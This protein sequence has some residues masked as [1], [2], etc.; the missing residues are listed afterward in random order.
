MR[1]QLLVLNPTDSSVGATIS[2]QPAAAANS[3]VTVDVVRATSLDATDVTFNGAATP[4]VDLSEPGSVLATTAGG[5][6]RHDF[7]PFSITLLGWNAPS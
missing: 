6:V 4:T 5:A 1:A 7:P 2:A 3:S